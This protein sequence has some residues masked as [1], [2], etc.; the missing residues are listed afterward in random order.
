MTA[1]TDTVTGLRPA[2][3][4]AKFKFEAMPPEHQR[5]FAETPPSAIADLATLARDPDRLREFA[6]AVRRDSA[7]AV[8]PRTLAD[9]TTEKDI[10]DEAGA[11]KWLWHSWLQ[12]KAVNIISAEEGC[13]KTRFCVELL[14]RI[15]DV[16]QWPD[17]SPVPATLPAD[18]KVLWVPADQNYPEL[19][20]VLTEFGV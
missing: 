3:R 16:R 11:V 6:S 20:S 15:R 9:V 7:A 19:T 4:A 12:C 8:T 17:G 14:R 18:S 5:L 10:M 13:G 2:E 1:A